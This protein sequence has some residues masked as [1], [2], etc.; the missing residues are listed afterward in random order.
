[1][2][3]SKTEKSLRRLVVDLAGAAPEDVALILADLTP[4]HRR[5]VEAMFAELGEARVEV[6]PSSRSAPRLASVIRV[7]DLSPEFRRRLAP[8]AL[9]ARTL[10][11]QA[12]VEAAI[13]EIA[14]SAPRRASILA[15]V[16]GV[17]SRLM[18]G[19]WRGAVRS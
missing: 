15:Q 2:P 6:A 19:P 5:K 10:A 1:M 17:A 11:T 9:G 4:S 7:L 16:L 14:A 8:G 18:I 12:A 13:G 3:L